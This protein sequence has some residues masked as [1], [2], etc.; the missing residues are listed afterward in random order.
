M[1][2]RKLQKTQWKEEALDSTL[3]RTGCVRGC[4]PVVRQTTKLMNIV[5]F[6]PLDNRLGDSY[7][8]NMFCVIF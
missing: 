3:W 2:V 5:L 8:P 4:G 1:T 6:V 7:K